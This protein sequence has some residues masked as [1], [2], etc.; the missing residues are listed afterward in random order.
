MFKKYCK[1]I[2]IFNLKWYKIL[3]N[4]IRAFFNGKPLQTG[5]FYDSHI[6]KEIDKI[7]NREQP[8][9]IFCQ[10]IRVANYV[11]HYNIPKTLDYQDV[12]SKG[13]ERRK[14]KVCFLLKPVFSTEYKRLEQYESDIFKYFTHKIIISEADRTHIQHPE[15]NSIRIIPNGVDQSYFKPIEKEKKYDLLFTGNMAYPPN[16]HAALY[17]ITDIL[18]ALKSDFPDITLLIAGASP[19]KKLRIH[20]SKHIIITGYMPD[21]R[22]CYWESRIFVAPMQLGTGLQNKL[23]EAMSM[24]LPCVSSVLANNALGAVDGK[25]ILLGENTDTYKK[26]ITELLKNTDYARQIGM[27]GYSFVSSN[28]N[29]EKLTKGIDEMICGGG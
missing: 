2:Y 28:F 20:E 23:L 4:L 1:S 10:L 8:E 21:I 22:E 16:I 3:F 14:D 9:H 11:K 25:E 13:I 24:Q 15:K 12:F 5:Y 19:V 6:K 7:I 27:A 18:P 29:W 26:H 17:L